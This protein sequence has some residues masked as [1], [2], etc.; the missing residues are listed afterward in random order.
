MSV[1]TQCC[2]AIILLNANLMAAH[3]TEGLMSMTL[4]VPGLILRKS[5][6]INSQSI[7]TQAQQCG[8][9]QAF[10]LPRICF[11]TPYILLCQF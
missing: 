4:T 1:H 9:S 10:V 7:G 11:H 2:I 5:G 3:I 6:E 8:V